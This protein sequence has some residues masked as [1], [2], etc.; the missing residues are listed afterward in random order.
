[1]KKTA[2]LSLVLTLICCMSAVSCGG[3]KINFDNPVEGKDYK[4]SKKTE[5][6][7]VYSW[8]YK[9]FG[10]GVMPIAGFI[11]PTSEY[12]YEGNL[13]PN[14]I[15]DESYATIKD[16]GLNIIYGHKEDWRYAQE[17]IISSLTYAE[18]YGIKYLFYDTSVIDISRQGLVAS[19]EDIRTAVSKYS[20][21]KACLLYTS[22]A[23][24]D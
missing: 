21:Y 17:D 20:G 13:L 4:I 14:R 8:T 16:C 15:T 10:E 7:E 6:G 9:D 23:A 2:T 5:A 22:D 18:K 3:G 11:G 1:M 19:T 12:P 24:D